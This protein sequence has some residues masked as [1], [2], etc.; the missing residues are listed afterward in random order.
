[1]EKKKNNN[2]L[3]SGKTNK[4]HRRVIKKFIVLLKQ[5]LFSARDRTSFLLITWLGPQM[6]SC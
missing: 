2:T 6:Y 4:N 1:M 5:P 3:W